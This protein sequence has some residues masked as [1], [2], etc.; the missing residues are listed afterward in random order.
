MSIEYHGWVVLAT[1]QGDW[2]DGDFDGGYG[3]VSK[4]IA[5]LSHDAGHE[6]AL[7]DCDVLPKVLYLKGFGVESLDP[8]FRVIEEVG[9]LFDRSYG[10]I[11]VWEEGCPSNRGGSPFVT[12]YFLTNGK[13]THD[14]RTGS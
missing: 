13:L 9:S 3:Q 5:S 4:A 8:V 12:R 7:P 1:S 11:A 14:G 6:P 2:S 10:E